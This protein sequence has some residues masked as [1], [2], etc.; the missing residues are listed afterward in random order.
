MSN[1][2]LFQR[3]GEAADAILAAIPERPRI[4]VVL[5]SGLGALADRLGDAVAI[6]YGQIPDFPRPSVAGHGGHL[7]AGRL[8]GADVLILQG[9]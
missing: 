9:R 6:P 1:L 4:A 5:G 2:D 7:I 3:A 8:S